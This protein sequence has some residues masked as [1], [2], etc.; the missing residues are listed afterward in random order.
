MRILITGDKGFIGRQVGKRLAAAGFQTEGFDIIDGFDVCNFQSLV[1]KAAGCQVITHLAAIEEPSP[2]RTMETNVLGT[3]NVLCAA[4]ETNVEK[5]IFLSSVDAL[6]VFQGE[7]VPWY[8]PLDDDY[9]CHPCSPY[10]ISKKLA[11]ELCRFFSDAT[12]IPILCLRPPGVWDESTYESIMAAR[13][14]RPD[15]EWDPYW[16]YG[17]FI[18]IRDLAEAVLAAVQQDGNGFQC[19]L[20]AS[21][22]ITT[23]GLSSLEL[24]HKLHP[25][26][27]WKGGEAYNLDPFKSLVNTDKAK[28]ALNWS[29][30]YSWR[31]YQNE[32]S[33]STN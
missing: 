6:G 2:T 5:I 12:G 19:Y 1:Q 18:D 7:A 26:V 32:R 16:E 20:V 3:W 17:A 8:L 11:E 29:P 4:K 25:D 27:P 10:S 28:I 31:K 21:D 14:E 9:P 15:Y 13:Q 23:S 33:G 22:D 30:K 24:V